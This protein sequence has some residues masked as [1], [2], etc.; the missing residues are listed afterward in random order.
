MTLERSKVTQS[1]LRKGFIHHPKNN[2]DHDFYVFHING[3]ATT[4]F[5]K[6]SRGTKYKDLGNDLV[7]S[8]ASQ[9]RLD[10][11]Q[12]KEFVDCNLTH[13]NYKELLVEK[14]I[15]E[16]EPNTTQEPKILTI[17]E[18]V[19]YSKYHSSHFIYPVYQN[20]IPRF[21]LVPIN[22]H[23]MDDPIDCYE[24]TDTDINS[25]SINKSELGIS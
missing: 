5:T 16:G 19:D 23:N 20:Q 25:I 1:L 15:V 11:P 14:N 8:M 4:I 22:F 3:K 13:D 12:F 6:V 21:Y 17:E 9:I 24:I 18:L 10:I 7:K 2:S